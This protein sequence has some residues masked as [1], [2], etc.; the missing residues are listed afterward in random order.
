MDTYPVPVN[1]R[2]TCPNF[3]ALIMRLPIGLHGANG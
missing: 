2:A 1:E 3:H